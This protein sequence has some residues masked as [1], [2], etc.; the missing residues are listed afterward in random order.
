MDDVGDD[1]K[2]GTYP[3]HNGEPVCDLLQESYPGWSFLLLGQLVVALLCVAAHS[4][5][6]AHAVLQ[7]SPE[8]VHQFLQRDLVL[9]HALDLPRLLLRLPLLQLLLILRLLCINLEV[10][11]CTFLGLGASGLSPLD[12]LEVL[13]DLSAAT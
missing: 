2:N 1:A 10:P 4:C 13:L 11:V 7:T 6:G 3:E 8:A 5:L 12:I 9:I